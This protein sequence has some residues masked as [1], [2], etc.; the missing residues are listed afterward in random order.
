MMLRKQKARLTQS[1]LLGVEDWARLRNSPLG[2][3]AGLPEAG[4]GFRRGCGEVVRE[5]RRRGGGRSANT[6]GHPLRM[7][8]KHTGQLMFGRSGDSNCW[9]RANLC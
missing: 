4:A 8:L 2:R 6:S 5:E 9:A 7:S 3:R 1:T